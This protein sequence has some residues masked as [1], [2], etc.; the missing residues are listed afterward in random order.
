MV[1]LKII[2]SQI[3]AFGLFCASPT[4]EHWTGRPVNSGYDTLLCWFP[5]GKRDMPVSL[6]LNSADGIL[7]AFVFFLILSRVQTQLHVNINVLVLLGR[8]E[9]GKQNQYRWA[10]RCILGSPFG[11]GV[12]IL[13]PRATARLKIKGWG[14][15][16]GIWDGLRG[17]TE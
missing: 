1:N 15:F 14:R 8:S 12:Y 3:L 9:V 10:S 6:Q 16:S 11:Q 2:A 7:P 5:P 17:W 13:L 4:S